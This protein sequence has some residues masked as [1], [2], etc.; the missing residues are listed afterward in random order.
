MLGQAASGAGKL[1]VQ[2]TLRNEMQGISH[3]LIVLVGSNPIETRRT[4][5]IDRGV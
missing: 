3:F 2:G 5:A 1:G 4:A